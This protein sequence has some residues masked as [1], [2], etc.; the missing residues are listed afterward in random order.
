LEKLLDD[1]KV[2]K[3]PNLATR[4]T[5]FLES[6]KLPGELHLNLD[7]LREM[8]N[9]IHLNESFVTGDVLEISPE[10]AG[11]ALDILAD[12]FEELYVRPKEQQERRLAFDA[13]QIETTRNIAGS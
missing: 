11:W 9:F 7:K 13:K 8:G 2:K 5:T 4:I 12:L 3:G 10:E 6:H 1:Q